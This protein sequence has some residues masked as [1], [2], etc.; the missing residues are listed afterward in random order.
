MNFVMHQR[1]ERVPQRDLREPRHVLMISKDDTL[2]RSD[3]AVS[4]DS[5][6]RHI[7]YLSRLALRAPGSQIRILTKSTAVAPLQRAD[8]TP[9]LRIVG[10]RSRF[11]W[12]YL[13]GC[14]SRSR[15]VLAEGWRPTVVTSQTPFEDGLV[16]LAIAKRTGARFI[17]QL[18]F[19]LFSDRWIQERRLNRVLKH[20]ARWVL[21]RSDFVRVVT[22]SQ[23]EELVST[24][25]MDPHRIAVV[26]VSVSYRPLPN[27]LE[28][29]RQRISPALAGCKVMLFVGRFSAEKNLPLWINVAERVLREE[30][31]ARFVMAGNG[32][33]A[34]HVHDLLRQ[35]G[36]ENYFVLLGEVPYSQLP[37]VYAGSDVLLL[38]SNHEGFGRVIVEA[39]L[40]GVPVVSTACSGPQEIIVDDDTGYLCALGDASALAQKA[41][42]LLRN[43]VLRAE[44][45]RAGERKVTDLFSP[46]NLTSRIVDLWIR[47]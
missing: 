17:A 3:G 37:S 39:Y 16:G 45:A 24:F 34:K 35:K 18:H 20:L 46:A 43:S 26:P 44:F 47:A 25:G 19:D 41:L 5:Q 7:M 13:I 10:T 14:L 30:P 8:P 31:L 2:L 40:S 6:Q 36:L 22:Q 42:R 9:G 33:M 15:E 11:R 12:T 38:T 1:C 27:R 29:H 23:K 32:P 28:Q 4:S 21:Q